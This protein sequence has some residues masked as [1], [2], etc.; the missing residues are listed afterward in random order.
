MGNR[1]GRENLRTLREGK[2]FGFVKFSKREDAQRAITRLEGFL[3]LGKKIRVKI[4]RYSGKRII[5]KKVQAKEDISQLK[6]SQSKGMRNQDR[7]CDILKD[8]VVNNSKVIVGHVEN[9][10][11][12]K[13]QRC[14]IGET[15]SFCNSNSLSERI[16][17]MGLGELKV[18]RL[19]GRYF[20]VEVPDEELLEILRQREWAYLK[21][22]FIN[23]EPW[24]KKFKV[25]KGQYGLKLQGFLFIAGTTKHL[26]EWWIY[27]ARLLRWERILQWQTALIR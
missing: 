27:G 22:F 15:A 4:A 7:D 11:L 13:L 1:S 20:L 8:K 25:W 14:L 19:Q 16:A 5:W 17:C 21:E 24:S 3:M 10:Q 23:I 6:V 9:E 2:R 26:R 18:K 12:W